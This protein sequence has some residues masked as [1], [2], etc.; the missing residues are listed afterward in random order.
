MWQSTI[1]IFLK[2][3][4]I[5]LDLTGPLFDSISL[6]ADIDSHFLAIT[7]TGNKCNITFKASLGVMQSTP[8]IQSIAL[9]CIPSIKSQCSCISYLKDH[10]YIR[11]SY[12]SLFHCICLGSSLSA[13]TELPRVDVTNLSVSKELISITKGFETPTLVSTLIIASGLA[14]NAPSIS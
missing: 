6:N 2:F 10:G 13:T 5:V 4:R 14:L 8:L 12:D 1:P 7:T 11:V 9:P 3:L